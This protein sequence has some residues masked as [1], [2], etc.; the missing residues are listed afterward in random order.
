MR[1]AAHQKFC[2]GLITVLGLVYKAKKRFLEID[3]ETRMNEMGRLTLTESRDALCLGTDALLLAAYIK[4]NASANAVE[5]GAGSG[6]ISLLVAKRGKFKKITAV[7][8]QPELA[9]LCQKNVSDNGLF[10]TV[11]TVCAD[12]R[13]LK[14]AEYA[15]T[16]VVFANPPYMKNDAGKV[17]PSNFRQASRHEVFGGVK[18]FCA[19]AGK[20]L[21]TGGRFYVVYR[22]DRLES[23]IVSLAE[24]GFTPKRMT[25][26]SSDEYHEPSVVLTEAVKDAKE[27]LFITPPLF[28]TKDGKTSEEAEYIYANGEFPERFITRK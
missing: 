1:K 16:G 9:E 17:S 10:D 19:C 11:N 14:N 25:F 8:I 7:E 12:V 28:L 3:M 15:G 2:Y 4:K 21:K 5:L 23:L 27:S 24:F 13:S 26:V 6:A 18:E 20:L 22:P